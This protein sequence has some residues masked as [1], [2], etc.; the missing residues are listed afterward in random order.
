MDTLVT[1]ND[2]KKAN[3]FL[4]EAYS[5]ASS[6]FRLEE[7][8]ESKPFGLTSFCHVNDSIKWYK[9]ILTLHKSIG[10]D[11]LSLALRKGAINRNLT[12]LI[13]SDAYGQV[14]VVD[15][16]TSCNLNNFLNEAYRKYGPKI[17]LR[18]LTSFS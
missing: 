16:I 8:V 2:Y 5:K 6:I 7:F 14:A 10:E 17:I 11:C 15:F 3:E 9:F 18:Y 4:Y 12:D 13:T 1:F